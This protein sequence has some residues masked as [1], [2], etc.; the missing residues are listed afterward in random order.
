LR[1]RAAIPEL[2][3]LSKE[4]RRGSR[5]LPEAGE[6]FDAHSRLLARDDALL[7]KLLGLHFTGGDHRR[8]VSG[9]NAFCF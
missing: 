7:L 1:Q 9:D 8:T 6:R 5:S 3:R 2:A 4:Y